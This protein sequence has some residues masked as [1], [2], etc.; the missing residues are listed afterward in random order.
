MTR[1]P[2]AGVR[3]ALPP[4]PLVQ[5]GHQRQRSPYAGAVNGGQPRGLDQQPL[6]QAVLTVHGG[7]RVQAHRRQQLPFRC[8]GYRTCGVL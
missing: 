1:S 3:L 6:M 7:D 4:V 5:P 2:M 8:T